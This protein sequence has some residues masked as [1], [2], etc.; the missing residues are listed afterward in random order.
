MKIVKKMPSADRLET[1]NGYKT[2]Y[3]FDNSKLATLAKRNKILIIISLILS[4]LSII[5]AIAIPF[6]IQHVQSEDKENTLILL[7]DLTTILKKNSQEIKQIFHI[8][9]EQIESLQKLVQAHNQQIENLRES[10]REEN[11]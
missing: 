8:N 9:N 11:F 7:R 4:F 10:G 5:V 2:Y 6:F 3:S 1:E